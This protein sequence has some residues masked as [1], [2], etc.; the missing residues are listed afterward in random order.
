MKNRTITD[1]MPDFS[2]LLADRTAN[3]RASIIRETLKVAARPDIISLAGG[4]P[5]PE[6]FPIDVMEELAGRVLKKYGWR[7]LQYGPSEGF[8]PLREVLVDLMAQR[9][10][11]ATSDEII[12]TSGSQGA[13]EA[14]AQILIS[15]GDKVAL[16]APTYLGALTAF[17]PYRPDYVAVDTDDAGMI[18]E[19]LDEILGREPIKFVYLVPNFQN[20]TGRTIGLERREQIAEIII[21]HKVL[22]VEDDAYSMLR[23][24]GDS[25]LPIKVFA[26]HNVVYMSTMSKVLSPGLRIGFCVAPELIR[27]W[28]VLA[29]QGI[30]LHTSSFDQ[31]LAAEYIAGGY[32]ERQLPRILNL[33]RPRLEAIL[34]ALE[35]Y[36]NPGFRWSRPDGGMFIWAEGPQGLDTSE[37]YW[38][39]IE[40]GVAYVP[41]KFFFTRQGEG[42]AT[43]RLNFTNADSDKLDRAIKILSKVFKD[44]LR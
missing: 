31:A 2:G 8:Q 16:E 25:I 15:G 32:L 5:A 27:K 34:A 43:M 35:K 24:R 11:R 10:I 36:F 33:Y 13:L 41:G 44:S 7:S 30:D 22:L 9:G 4:L 42:L 12:V 29:K 6:S 37:V 3:M 14:V 23:Y 38:T 39:A 19:S 18:P 40:R 26:P 28:M 20:P 1:C 21:K 17:N